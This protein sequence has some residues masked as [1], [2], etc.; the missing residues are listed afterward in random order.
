MGAFLVNFPGRP[1]LGCGTETGIGFQSRLDFVS[2]VDG[3]LCSQSFGNLQYEASP[4]AD[5]SRTYCD[6]FIGG[7]TIYIWVDP[8]TML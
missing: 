5:L 3:S 2:D 7:L 4:M 1:C 8:D 6:A